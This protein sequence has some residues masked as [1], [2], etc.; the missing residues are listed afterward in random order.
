MLEKRFRLD[1]DYF[2]NTLVNWGALAPWT[3]LSY[4]SALIYI[5]I[6]I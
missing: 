6:Y 3:R 4:A 1:L 5:Y 2:L